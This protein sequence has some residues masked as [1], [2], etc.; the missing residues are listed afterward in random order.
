MFAVTT[1]GGPEQARL[2]IGGNPMPEVP[3]QYY[4]GTFEGFGRLIAKVG[5]INGDGLNDICVGQSINPGAC[6]SGFVLIFAGDTL[7]QQPVGVEQE[8]N[9]VPEEFH[10]YEPYPNPFNPKTVI[11]Y[12]SSVIGNVQITVYDMLGKEIQ[13]LV[14]EEKPSG[15]YKVE[16]DGSN[17]SSGIYCYK[18]TLTDAKGNKQTQTKSMVLIK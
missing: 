17:L 15:E 5:D 9:L 2:W 12:Q 18:L 3:K 8:I 10:L 16:F 4:G 14:N 11:G 7:F 6:I 1:F 13:V